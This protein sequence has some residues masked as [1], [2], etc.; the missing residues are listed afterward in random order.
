[1]LSFYHLA[2]VERLFCTRAQYAVINHINLNILQEYLF[3]LVGELHISLN[4]QK[5]ELLSM[6][7]ICSV[8]HAK[9]I[10]IQVFPCCTKQS[11]QHL[12]GCKNVLMICIPL[13]ILPLSSSYLMKPY[14]ADSQQK[15]VKQQCNKS[16]R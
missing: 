2:E 9:K 6:D 4:D 11:A 13:L 14:V 15:V 3:N 10:S 1:M 12:K 5:G 7:R 16:L 8:Q